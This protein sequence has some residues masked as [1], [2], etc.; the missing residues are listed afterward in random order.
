MDAIRNCFGGGRSRAPLLPVHDANVDLSDTESDNAQDPLLPKRSGAS[1]DSSNRWLSHLESGV[2]YAATREP[3]PSRFNRK[4]GGRRGSGRVAEISS[5]EPNGE[6]PHTNANQSG[7][8]TKGGHI[9]RNGSGNPYEGVDEKTVIDKLVDVFAALSKGK[10]PTQDQFTRMLQV[11]LSSD[12]LR[13][14]PITMAAESIYGT[15]PSSRRGQKVIEDARNLVQAML[16][17]TMEKND[18]NKFQDLICNLQFI[19]VPSEV[20]PVPRPPKPKVNVEV[21]VSGAAESSK[22]ALHKGE[23]GVEELKNQIP[24][25]EELSNDLAILSHAL[26][27]LLT[28]LLTSSVF[29]FLLADILEI[30]RDVIAHGATDIEAAAISVEHAAESVEEK[31][32]DVDTKQLVDEVFDGIKERKGKGVEGSKPEMRDTTKGVVKKV[33]EGVK[34]LEEKAGE[35]MDEWREVGKDAKDTMKRDFVERMQQVS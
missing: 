33:S 25:S 16:Q 22:D 17:F 20:P 29:R 6:G 34:G 9:N 21:D 2:E 27:T 8:N 14:S 32:K 23:Q 30:F 7:S 4:R 1:G 11:L 10:L 5:S 24:T 13:S 15:G 19:E 18:D 3:P 26:R 35:K 31:A 28:S 12:V